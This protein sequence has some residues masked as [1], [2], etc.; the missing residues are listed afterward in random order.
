MHGHAARPEDRT[1][2][3][4]QDRGWGLKEEEGLFGTRAVELGD[5]VATSRVNFVSNCF[6]LFNGPASDLRIVPPYAHDLDTPL[7]MCMYTASS[8]RRRFSKRRS[9]PA[10][11]YSLVVRVNHPI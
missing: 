1:S 7:A 3:W 5:V 9:E 10:T 4:E 2:A 6:A 11:A 8:L